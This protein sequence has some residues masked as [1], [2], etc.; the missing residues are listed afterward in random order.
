MI[1][2]AVTGSYASGKSFVLEYVE[3]LGYKTFSADKCIKELYKKPEIQHMVLNILPELHSFD[4]NSISELIYSNDEA[5]NRLQH[6]M[7]PF[8]I[9]ALS[10]FKE[11]NSKLDITFAEIP[12]LFEAG[13]DKYFD[14][15]VTTF[16]S[17]E[18]RLKRAEARNSF[19]LKSYNKIKQI[20]LP[21]EIKMEK[22]D[23]VINTDMDINK[24]ITELIQR[25]NAAIK[26][27][28]P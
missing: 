6:L 22:S 3:D 26:R 17:E 12:L 27:N 23:F 16:C 9:E 11:Q 21:Q 13:F 7:H 24:Q 19:N 14:F 1:C 18:T 10:N 5:R 8:A 2:V 20:Q 15:Y 28:N 25:L 4:K